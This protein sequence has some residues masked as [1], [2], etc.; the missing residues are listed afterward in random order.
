M[1]EKKPY[2]LL[3]DSED[4]RKQELADFLKENNLQEKVDLYLLIEFGQSELRMGR[5]KKK[6]KGIEEIIAFLT[7]ELLNKDTAA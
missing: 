4:K 5:W 6:K 7:E 2:L 3:C 1:T